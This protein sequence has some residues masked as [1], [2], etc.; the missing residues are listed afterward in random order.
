MHH[1]LTV[2]LSSWLTAFA[3][4]TDITLEEKKAKSALKQ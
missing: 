4:S 2:I 3:S 1:L